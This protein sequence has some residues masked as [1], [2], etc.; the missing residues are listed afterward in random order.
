MTFTH[1]TLSQIRFDT[2][3]ANVLEAKREQLKLDSLKK[4]LNGN[5]TKKVSKSI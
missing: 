3:M 5:R 2:M 1:R 4:R